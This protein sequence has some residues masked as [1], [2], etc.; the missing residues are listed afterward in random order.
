MEAKSTMSQWSK[1]KSEGQMQHYQ[2]RFSSSDLLKSISVLS[3]HEPQI[4]ENDNFAVIILGRVRPINQDY[5]PSSAAQWLL[6][7]YQ[8]HPM[9]YYPEIAG[10]FNLILLDKTAGS[11][12]LVQDHIASLPLY[13]CEPESGQWLVSSS[14]RLLEKHLGNDALKLNHQAIFNYCY[15]HCI[16]SPGSIYQGVQKLPP[17]AEFSI[18]K[19]NQAVSRNLYVPQYNYTDAPLK[20]SYETCQQVVDDAVRRNICDKTGA[21]LSGGL[22]SSTVA[23]MMARHQALTPTFSIGFDAK[24][25]DETEYAKI[26]A[27][28]FA[29]EHK[30]HYLKPDEIVENFVEVAGYFD[31]PFG[32]SSAM[33]AYVCSKFALNNGIETML[34][35]DGGDEIFAGNGRYAKQKKFEKFAAFPQVLQ[36]LAEA[37][38]VNS[39][40][41]KI[42]GF[43]KVSSYIEQANVPLPDRLESYNYLNRFPLEQMFEKEF[44]A[45]I[46]SAEPLKLQRQRFAECSSPNTLEK[47]L[48]LDWKFTLADNDLVK[49]TQMCNKAGIDVRY[50]LLEKEVVNFSCTL[51]SDVK[52]PGQELRKFYKDAFSDFLSEKTINKA[53]HGFGLPFGVWMKTEEK[54]KT[55]THQCLQELKKRHIFQADFIDLALEKHDSEHSHYYGELIWVMVILELWL[56]SRGR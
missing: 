19:A 50:P 40:L 29:T 31:E 48:Y 53:K 12:S 17:G 42:G 51:A 37:V 8:Q 18:D 26:T 2:F 33:A 55:I 24:G 15:F 56:S 36:S 23:G 1:I 47:M 39:P 11:V 32:N 28:H 3:V 35:G 49:V 30:V 27:K 10:F 7:L 54:L 25:Y 13:V 43:N 52:L 6:D 38:F 46:D 5:F 21:F 22:D 34:G 9:D 14:N 16:P 44:L 41:A 20:A 45:S 4:A